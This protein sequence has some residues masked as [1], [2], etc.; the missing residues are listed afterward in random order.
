MLLELC[1]AIAH[2]V[3]IGEPFSYAR[4]AERRRAIERIPDAAIAPPDGESERVPADR[5]LHPFVGYVRV[6]DDAERDPAPWPGTGALLAARPDQLRV[7]VIG[8]SAAG[9]VASALGDALV[10]RGVAPDAVE[11]W[12]LAGAGHKQPQPVE[13]VNYL[14]ASGARWD[15]LVSVDGLDDV[16]IPVVENHRAGVY[17]YYPA[18]WGA[19]LAG[20]TDVASAARLGSRLAWTEL[21]VDTA[22]R[23][24]RSL[25]RL[26]PTANV[27]W[28]A[29]D[30]YAE[31]H[32]ERMDRALANHP[33]DARYQRRGPR[34]R[35]DE[36]LTTGRAADV[37]VRSSVL[38]HRIASQHG[39]T[40]LHFLQPNP[41]IDGSKPLSDEERARFI[42]AD[43][44]YGR[45]VPEGHA[46]LRARVPELEATG[47][48]FHDLTDVFA[49]EPETV[50]VGESGELNERGRRL[51][52]L[53]IAVAIAGAL[54]IPPPADEIGALPE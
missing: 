5:A 47:V 51:V 25:W 8:G 4:F 21:R 12:G 38:L 7:V 52:A 49:A 3:A 33:L 17:P 32:V 19:H 39:F 20:T 48:P 29:W 43:P 15:V 24:Q 42:D 54:E 34:F 23:L 50:Y 14:L 53:E 40:Y 41:Y 18:A 16:I 10:S 1:V 30:D 35:P 46:A 13:L 11:V 6:D 37:W 2:S 27:L 22:R 9:G 28:S 26:S 45:V 36:G 44:E 31:A